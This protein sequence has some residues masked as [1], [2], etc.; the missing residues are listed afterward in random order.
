MLGIPSN[1]MRPMAAKTS[2]VTSHACFRAATMAWACV[3]ALSAQASDLPARRSPAVPAFVE[4]PRV[5]GFYFATR[6]GVTFPDDTSFALGG[7]S[8]VVDT[9]YEVGVRSSAALGYD[10]GPVFGPGVGVRLEAEAGYGKFSVDEH[11]IN[12]VVAPSIGSFGDVT[13]ISGFASAFLDF[14]FVGAFRPFVGAGVGAA[15]VELRRQGVSATGVVM[16]SDDTRVAYHV[17]AGVGVDLAALGFSS[18]LFNRSV[19]EV[20][21]RFMHAPDLKFTARD[22]TRSETDFS[23]DMITV[24]FRRQF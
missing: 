22:G 16:D 12:G 24:G 4:A 9:D 14:T 7:G 23:A 8:V 19:F 18:A 15:N 17:S 11:R 5:G 2:F 20:G 1:R 21:Y 10:F 3:V 6:T 13:V